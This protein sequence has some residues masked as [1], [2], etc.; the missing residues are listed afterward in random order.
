MAIPHHPLLYLPIPYHQYVCLCVC[1]CVRACVRACVCVCVCVCVC[2]RVCACACVRAF[3]RV[4]VCV[5]INTMYIWVG[6]W[7]FFLVFVCL[8]D[9]ELF[10]I[11]F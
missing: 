8:Y 7:V 10:T 6:V 5:C 1:A 9:F 3:V 2:A 11:H 4:C